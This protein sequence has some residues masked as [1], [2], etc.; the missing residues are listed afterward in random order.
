M[1]DFQCFRYGLAIIL[2]IALVR[3]LSSSVFV[4][5]NDRD[6]AKKNEQRNLVKYLSLLPKQR[7]QLDFHCLVKVLVLLLLSM[8]SND[9]VESIRLLSS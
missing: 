2:V 9:N 3:F 6:V 1:Y 5:A 7:F 4:L 8:L